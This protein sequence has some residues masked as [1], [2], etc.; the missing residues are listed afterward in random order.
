MVQIYVIE[1]VK[2]LKFPRKFKF[3][4]N[5]KLISVGRVKRNPLKVGRKL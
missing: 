1:N 5:E 4:G 3:K 2:K